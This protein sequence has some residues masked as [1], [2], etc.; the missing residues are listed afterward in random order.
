MQEMESIQIE[1]LEKLDADKMVVADIRPREEYDRGT[2]PGAVSL[3]NGMNLKKRQRSCQRIK[4]SMCCAIRES[5][6]RNI[7]SVCWKWAV[8]Q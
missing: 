5:G 4:P 1:E 6:A 7:R 8:M 2:W 3:P